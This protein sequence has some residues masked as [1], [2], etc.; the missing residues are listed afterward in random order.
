MREVRSFAYSLS[1][2]D[3]GWRWRI[4]DEDG[5]TVAN[6]AHLDT[7]S[8]GTKQFQVTSMDNVG[9]VTTVSVGYQVHYPFTGFASPMDNLPTVN[10]VK[11]GAAA[12]AKFSLSGYRGNAVL[13]SGSP[14]SVQ[15]ACNAL[16]PLDS[17]TPTV[18]A[19][20][21]GLSYDA[22]ADQYSYVWKTDRSWSGTCRR[23]TVTLSD[24]TAHFLDFKFK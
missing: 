18:S 15:V 16:A 19:T 21:S 24:G 7:S 10:V 20:S 3:E 8:V 6:G 9:H 12:P 2:A 11:A 5:E 22:A 17:D 23:L 13:A 1:Q 4:Y 14:S